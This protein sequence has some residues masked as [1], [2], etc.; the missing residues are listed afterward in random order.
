MSSIVASGLSVCMSSTNVCD[1]CEGVCVSSINVCDSC[2]G[3]CVC[4]SETVCLSETNVCDSC[5][6]CITSPP[7]DRYVSVCL[8]QMGVYVL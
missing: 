3:V 7:S 1:S 4:P 2:K 5:E 6:V 8:E